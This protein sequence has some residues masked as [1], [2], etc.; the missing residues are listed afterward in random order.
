MLKKTIILTLIGLMILQMIV[1]PVSSSLLKTTSS[2]YPE[3]P[4][5]TLQIVFTGIDNSFIDIKSLN[6]SIHSELLGMPYISQGVLIDLSGI[7]TISR[8][9]WDFNYIFTSS[10]FTNSLK[11]KMQNSVIE[12]N[13]TNKTGSFI[14]GVA[15]KN[16][17][18]IPSNYNSEFT[19]PTNGYTLV[20]G[21]FSDIGNHW[22]RQQYWDYDTNQYFNRSFM[23]TIDSG[24]LFFIDLSIK[25]SYLDRYGANG[26]I[27]NL[28]NY[29]TN[30][31]HGK[32]II[33]QYF[34]DWIIEVSYDLFYSDLIYSTPNFF[35][36]LY[37]GNLS[38]IVE[39][40]PNSV[41]NID[42]Y[43]MNNVSGHTV[44]DFTS[45][46]N[47]TKID[48]AFTDL[49]PWY[50]W[51][52]DVNAKEVSAYNE[53]SNKILESFDPYA[54]SSFSGRTPGAID[55]YNV[56]EWIYNQIESGNSSITLPFLSTAPNTYPVFVFMFD[57]GIFGVPYKGVI[58]P[59][60][61]GASLFSDVPIFGGDRWSHLTLISQDSYNFFHTNQSQNK[62]GLTQVIIHETGHSV[63]LTHP[64]GFSY[65]A[66]MVDD[67][68]SYISYVYKF[69]DYNKDEVRRGEIFHATYYGIAYIR[70]FI[71]LPE[72]TINNLPQQ[73]I[74]ALNNAILKYQSI[75]P[76]MD[77][78]DYVPA[79]QK[80]WEFY[81]MAK[82]IYNSY[83]DY[84][85]I[86]SVVTKTVT[87]FLSDSTT[88]NNKASSLDLNSILIALV[89][90]PVISLYYR[91]KNLKK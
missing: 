9:F 40:A 44:S 91:K 45:Y 20:L 72:S 80:A 38:T 33:S 19:M 74:I 11:S 61:L 35:Q 2:Q 89:I 64:H 42:I 4:N 26:P 70:G 36:T 56:F 49:L 69:S 6:D 67:P 5:M 73:L 7:G 65:S 83:K 30:D 88:T 53:L 50:N 48:E 85:D 37:A 55:M 25:D 32:N 63:G 41:Q 71:E 77:V 54:N 84:I 59:Q 81:T 60:I 82:T 17:F 3:I 66:M 13:V 21:N 15:L 58:E 52:V 62:E 43:L 86:G 18:G 14:D 76:D 75:V 23:N 16:W 34:R 12:T 39:T 79:Y 28:A 68:M 1:S 31:I 78:M 47:A 8:A 22:F 90:I 24:R 29:N 46:I 10:T 57:K 27:Q 87:K 51:V